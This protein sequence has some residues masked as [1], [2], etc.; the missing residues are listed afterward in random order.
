MKGIKIF[1]IVLATG[2]VLNFCSCKNESGAGSSD[3]NSECKESQEVE[4]MLKFDEYSLE[5]YMKPVWKGDYVYN[6]TIMLVGEHDA[7]TLLY[8]AK[9]IIEVRSYD[10]KTKYSFQKDYI[11]D[12]ERNAI[13]R[14]AA[15]DIPFFT[16]K[17]YYPENGTFH[18]VSKNSGILFS[19]GALFSDKQLCVTYIADNKDGVTAPEDSSPLYAD[20]IRKLSDGK[21]VKI[22][23]Y[24]DSITVGANGS[25]FMGIEPYMPGFDELVCESLK[26][27]Y[28]NDNI[29]VVNK[30]VGGKNVV[31]GVE[32]VDVVIKENA[33]LVV[34][35]WGMNDCTGS[36]IRF[37][38][39]MD[40][41][42]K[43]IKSKN[44]EC[45]I[46]LVS[47][48][49]PNGDVKE[50]GVNNNYKNSPLTLFEEE[51]ETLGKKYSCGL[52]KVTRMHG[53]ML[54]KKQYYSMTGNNINHPTDFLIRTYAQNILFTLTGKEL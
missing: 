7:A 45:A 11:Y 14:R 47:S 9:R 24:G 18:S 5:T 25:G 50:T 20:F 36:S 39:A 52:A 27:I 35:C 22:C 33:D 32:H 16:E 15:S 54:E 48:M 37:G 21:N 6:E 4:E 46:L 19:E 3:K 1:A 41:M 34:L 26:K 2:C 42:I 40:T 17:E 10:L 51:L 12:E 29:E 23:F 31:W 53:E 8:P 38:A 44:P 49:Y 30:A 28:D 13:V 43:K